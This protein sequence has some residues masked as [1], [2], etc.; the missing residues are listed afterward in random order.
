F[1]ARG[2]FSQNVVRSIIAPSGVFGNALTIPGQNPYL[3]TTIR[4]QLCTANGI[5]LGPTCDNNPAI[6]LPAVYRRLVELGPRIGNYE[7]QLYDARIG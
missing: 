4:N 2:T 1:Y 6:P 5:A 7:T 3:N